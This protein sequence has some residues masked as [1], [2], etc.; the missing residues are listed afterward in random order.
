MTVWNWVLPVLDACNFIRI[1]R[2]FKRHLLFI[3]ITNVDPHYT[4]VAEK[5]YQ[6]SRRMD[7][8]PSLG[9]I[10]LIRTYPIFAFPC[11]NYRHFM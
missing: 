1:F 10:D 5:P 11:A 6:R 3:L 4:N 2:F 9:L 8:P 7:R